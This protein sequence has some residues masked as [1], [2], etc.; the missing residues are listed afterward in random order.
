MRKF[1]RAV[2]GLRGSTD[3]MSEPACHGQDVRTPAVK[4]TTSLSDLVCMPDAVNVSVIGRLLEEISW[5]GATVSGYRSGGHG[6]ENVL[7][8]EVLQALD[9]LPRAQFLG[10]VVAA[11]HG[12]DNA[13]ARLIEATEDI[14]VTLLPDENRVG[15]SGLVVQPD[16]LLESSATHVLVE[17]KRILSSSFQPEQLAR[18]YLA[19]M[20]D[21][22][23]K[24]PLLLL[25]LGSSPPVPVKNH[26][27]MSI[28]EA[29][30]LHLRSVHERTGCELDLAELEQQV[31]Q[32]IAWITWSDIQDVVAQQARDTRGLP[33]SLSGTVRRLSNSLINA[34]QWH[35]S[36]P[37]LLPIPRARPSD[38][39]S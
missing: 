31:A 25:L 29:V 13:R 21:A 2:S 15:R 6:R 38:G 1:S 4:P 27:R 14:R 28:T 16:A 36:R 17:A 10:S 33:P 8:A 32:R 30:L 26:G 5:E 20:Q 35:S 7:T 19:L 3:P 9:Y 22:A 12:A 34:I 18:E 23:G 39:R 24:T 11:A 37:T